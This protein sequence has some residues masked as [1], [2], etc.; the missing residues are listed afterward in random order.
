MR[1]SFFERVGM[2]RVLSIGA[3]I[4]LIASPSRARA[5]AAS[6]TYVVTGQVLGI[7]AAPL[8]NAEVRVASSA[9]AVLRILQSDSAG[10]F[11]FDRLS[12]V[13][14]SVRV[15]AFGY[16]PKT[17]AV[18]VSAATPRA[19]LTIQLE[20]VAAELAGMG[21]TE[22][23]NDPDKKLA[24]Y[25]DRRATNSFAHFVDGDEI[26][27]RKPQFVSEMLRGMGGVTLQASDKLGNILHIRGCSP[28]VW[29]DGVRMPG[30]QLDEVAPAGDVAGI[31][32]YN[33]FAGIPSRYFDRT[34]T[35]GT[36]LV[37]LRS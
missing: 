22:D 29:V 3:A 36:I 17:V 15:R 8:A 2:R 33:S 19:R 25:R 23:E 13:P 28:L 5:Q 30:A 21:I 4:G 6:A 11:S 12:E 24:A 26:A 14:G 37:W 1:L 7:D 20:S 31:E 27:R 10:R 34:A 32:I 16:A 18:T 35:C 9:G